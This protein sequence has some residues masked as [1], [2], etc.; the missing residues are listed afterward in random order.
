MRRP[1]S[2]LVLLLLAAASVFADEV[3]KAFAGRNVI[4]VIEEFRAAG[5]PFA[6]STNLVTTDLVVIEEPGPG[7]PL[8]V[9]RQLLRP[10]GLTVEERAGVYLVMRFDAE[11]LEL[12]SILLVITT[13]DDGEPMAQAV[14]T[15]RPGLGSS[16]A[17]KPGIYEY[18]HVTP[19]RYAFSIEAAGFQPVRKVVDVW[20]GE[21]KVVS[22]GMDV[23]R[24]EIE[25]IAVSASRYEILR[26]I[27]ASRFVLDQRTIQSMPDI[28]EDPMRVTQ[29]LPGAAA[30]GASA[31]TH[32]RGGE[33]GEIGIMLNGQWLF[34]PFHIRDYQSIFSA[35]D[36]RAIEGVEVYTGGF[37]VR[38][39]NR[40]SGLVLMESLEPPQPRHTEIG[41][42]VFNTSFLTAGNGSDRHWVLSARRGNLDLVIRPEF[43]QPSYYDVFGEFSYDFSPDATLSVNALYAD[44]KVEVILESEPAE[45]ERVVSKTRN[46]Q[47]WVQLDNRWSDELSSQTVISAVSFTNSRSGALN[48]EEKI[49]ASVDDTREIDQFGFR[50]EFTF[51]TGG[52]HLV[53]WG[54]QA[55]YADAEYLYSNTAEYFGLQALYEGRDEPFARDL[56]AS[57]DGAGYSLYFSDR[58]KVSDRSVLEW[59]L[60]WDDQSYPDA[61]SD[62]QLSPRLSYLRALGARTELRLSW[63][64]YHQP[65]QIHELQIEDGITDF[66]PA[67]RADHVIAGVRHLFRDKYALRVELFS[68][69]MRQVRPRFENL[70]DPLGLIPEV[71][72]DRVRL[73]PRS[74]SAR[75]LELSI[76]R[77]EGPLTWWATYVLSEVTDRIDGREELRSWD[78]RH[79]FQGGVSWSNEKWD[80]ALASSVHTGWPLTEL[81]LVENGLDEDGEIQY[82]AVPGPRN[83]GRHPSFASLDFRVSRTWKLKRGS[84]MAFFEVSNLTN[85][86]NQCCLDWDLEEDEDTGEEVFERGVDYWMPLLPAIGVLWEF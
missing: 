49:V 70:Y 43:G 17:I 7:A 34:D 64:R 24:P 46:A 63:G 57:P 72:P 22:V 1:F 86:R 68:K 75:G 55:T 80:V 66:W 51:N 62:S 77:S 35:I 84:F 10:H 2:L 73:D 47:F 59:G 81:A 50:Q 85:R 11:G 41:I 3:G 45:L 76:D 32:F 18:A 78:Q 38:F 82:L 54:L 31:R 44:D 33:Q 69:D 61:G 16:T 27:A 5:E 56:A 8:D 19:G 39:G 6:Y 37:P 71:Q 65:Q 67:Q 20:P 30:S 52:R 79:A 25:T 21:T 9:V 40:M 23:A 74:A 4:D 28:G 29:R 42:S 26:D 15:V 13:E 83:A 12:G 58:W 14:V 53:Q 48:D 60:R 36:S